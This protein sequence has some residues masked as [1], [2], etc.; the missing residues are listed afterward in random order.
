M[1]ITSRDAGL[2]GGAKY[3]KGR[4]KSKERDVIKD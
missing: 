3:N 1:E 4:I 2:G